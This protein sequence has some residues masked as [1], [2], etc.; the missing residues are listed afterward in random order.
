MW[1]QVKE[2]FKGHPDLLIEF[3]QFLPDP[4]DADGATAQKP[5]RSTDAIVGGLR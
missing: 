2:L 1:T 5:K 4:P 3:K